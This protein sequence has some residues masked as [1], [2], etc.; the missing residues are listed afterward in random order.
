MMFLAKWID[1]SEYLNILET[2][3]EALS[4]EPDRVTKMLGHMGRGMLVI[5]V[6]IGIIILSTIAINKIFSDKK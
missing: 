1:F 2:E 5:F 4:F 3:L 6:V